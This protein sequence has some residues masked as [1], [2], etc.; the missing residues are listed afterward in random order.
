VIVA[1]VTVQIGARG[2][3]SLRHDWA[4]LDPCLVSRGQSCEDD[5]CGADWHEAVRQAALTALRDTIGQSEL[6]HLLRDRLNA[7]LDL[8]QL[9]SVRQARYVIV[10]RY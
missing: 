7:N 1:Q 3:L 4:L 6:D 10:W 8:K 5:Y 2:R 9:L